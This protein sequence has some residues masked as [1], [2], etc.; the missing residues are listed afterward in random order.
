[1]NNILRGA[2]FFIAGAASASF[3]TYK[4]IEKKYKNIADEEIAS[5]KEMYK[6]KLEKT[7]AETETVVKEASKKLDETIETIK[8]NPYLTLVNDLGY[9]NNKEGENM[10]YGKN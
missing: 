3:I 10:F 2:L 8:N 4:V 1:M 6:R 7:K 5:V 9:S